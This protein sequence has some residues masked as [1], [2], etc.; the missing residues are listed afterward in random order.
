MTQSPQTY[1]RPVVFA[2]LAIATNQTPHLRTRRTVTATCA[3]APS[4][5]TRVRNG[6]SLCFLYLN[7]AIV[8]SASSYYSCVSQPKYEKKAGSKRHQRNCQCSRCN[9]RRTKSRRM[10]SSK[11]TECAAVRNGKPTSKENA[12][13]AMHS[14]CQAKK[15][16]SASGRN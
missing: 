10:D 1:P 2:I 13:S 15:C 14:S 5:K 4:L 6:F 7:F 11:K 8:G 9:C 12:C 16:C 3:T